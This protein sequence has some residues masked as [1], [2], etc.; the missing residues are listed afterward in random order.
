[1]T[2]QFIQSQLQLVGTESQKGFETDKPE[3]VP[4]SWDEEPGGG[5]AEG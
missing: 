1:M 3:F 2:I 4:F 5:F